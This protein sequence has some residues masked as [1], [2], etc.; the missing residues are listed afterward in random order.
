MS[1]RD[2]IIGI[3]PGLDGAV[4]I[5]PA[6]LLWDTPTARDGRRRRYVVHLMAGFLAMHGNDARA[7]V[8][9][10]QA[11][12]G[13]GRSSIHSLGEGQGLWIGMLAA[14]RIPYTLIYPAKWKRAMMEGLGPEKDAARL[15]AMQLFPHLADQL[16]LKKHHGRAEALLL[17]EY[18]RRRL[19]A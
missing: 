2:T 1:R 11:F 8:E 5:L 13:Q 19:P 3:D 6:G 12:P 14:F 4:A 18:G 17:A 16:S 10:T 7:I 15:R 9:G